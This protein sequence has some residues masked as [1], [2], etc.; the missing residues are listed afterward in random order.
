VP[1]IAPARP[2]ALLVLRGLCKSY[3]VG[4][5]RRPTRHTV[6]R[7][8]SLT[9]DRGECVAVLDGGLGALTLLRCIAGLAGPDAGTLAWRDERGGRAPPP[10]RVLVSADWR[11]AAACLSV[12]DVLEGAVPPVRQGVAERRVGD[13]ADAAGLRPLLADAAATLPAGPRWRVG[14]GAALAAGAEWLLAELPPLAGADAA[15]VRAALRAAGGRGVTVVASAPAAARDAVPA[16]R[17]LLWR[18]GRL[19]LRT[20]AEAARRVAEWPGGGPAPLTL[21]RGRS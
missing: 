20:E 12:R 6:L 2:A 11:P 18:G 9:V 15:A 4:P 17:T 21:R 19:A 8:L 14:I 5:A 10:A 7:D 16:T 1:P 3:D 13:A